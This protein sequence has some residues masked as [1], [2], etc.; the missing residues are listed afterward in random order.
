MPD[1]F[2]HFMKCLTSRIACNIR[3]YISQETER[4]VWGWGG[5]YECVYVCMYVYVYVR[6][7]GICVI[8][9]SA[10]DPNKSSNNGHFL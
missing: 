9:V 6:M 5:I 2:W 8:C 1:I 4:D 7:P 3:I 10:F